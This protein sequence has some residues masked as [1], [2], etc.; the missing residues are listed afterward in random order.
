MIKGKVFVLLATALVV[1]SLASLATTAHAGVLVGSSSLI[2]TLQYS[3]SYTLGG[4]R[5]DGL[6]NDNSGGAYTVENNYGNPSR[7]WQPAGFSFNSPATSASPLAGGPGNTGAAT[8]LAQSGGSDY[9]FAYGLSN[10]YIVQADA[11]VSSAYGFMIGSYDAV[12]GHYNSANS[13]IVRFDGDGSINLGQS[14]V[15]S[16]VPVGSGVPAY[17]DWHNF[18]AEFNHNTGHVLIYV[19]QVLKD[20]VNL[21][22]FAGGAYLNYGNAAVGMAGYTLWWGDNFQVGTPQAVP[23]PS[24]I[25]LALGGFVGLVIAIRRRKKG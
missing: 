18:A 7:T 8:G 22:T 19:D 20:D 10:D 13:L 6:Y 11:I 15:Y 5:T 25:V 23:E 9:N 16:P 12:G 17:G 4:A 3:D 1:E 21:A 2:G 24:S 14:N